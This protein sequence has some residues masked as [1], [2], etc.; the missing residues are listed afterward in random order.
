VGEG[1][2]RIGF[3]SPAGRRLM[4]DV[5]ST[6]FFTGTDGVEYKCEIIG[7]IGLER[8]PLGQ[9]AEALA[10][11]FYEAYAA[12]MP[13]ACEWADVCEIDQEKVI[14]LASQLVDLFGMP[15][16]VAAALETHQSS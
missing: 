11:K 8:G 2:I 13:S 3:N 4:S 7:S 5:I 1:A 12:A 14:S 6:T 10:F 15:P 16:D 9:Y